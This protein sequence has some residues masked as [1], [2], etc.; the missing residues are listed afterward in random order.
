MRKQRLTAL[1]LAGALAGTT[2]LS[3]CAGQPDQQAA[4][5]AQAEDTA[6]SPESAS[7][8][9][10]EAADSA[11]DRSEQASDS[12]ESASDSSAEASDPADNFYDSVNHEQLAAWSI[13]EDKSSY[14]TFVVMENAKDERRIAALYLTGKDQKTR[15][16]GGF[17]EVEALLSQIREAKTVEELLR[18]TGQFN[19]DTHKYIFLTGFQISSDL[20]DSN[21]KMIMQPGVDTG[22]SR[23]EWLAEEE[24]D[25]KAAQYFKEYTQQLFELNGASEKEAAKK[26]EAVC[27]M[28][29]EIAK[30]GL[31]LA[32]MYDPEKTSNV[33]LVSE[34]PEAFPGVF[35]AEML[36]EVWGFAPE[37]RVNVVDVGALKKL[38]EYLTEEN[39]PLL[40]DYVLSTVYRN[41]AAYTTTDMREATLSYDQK[42]GGQ[43]GKKSEE[44]V[45]RLQI[46]SGAVEFE[47]GRLYAQAYSSEETKND[48]TGLIHE[49]IDVYRKRLT[50]LDWLG[51]ETRK[52]AI[53]KLEAID[54]R[55]AYPEVWE[56]DRYTAELKRPEDGGLYIDNQLAL[57][58]AQADYAYK[59][60]HDPV[61]KEYWVSAPQTV[62]AY[63]DPSANSITILSGILQAPFYDPEA[64]REENLGGIGFVIAHE[65]S[66]AFDTSGAQYDKNGNLAD[67]WTKEDKETFSRLANDVIAYYDRMGERFGR[68]NGT[69]TVT[70]NIADLGAISAVTELAKAEKLDLKKL[71]TAYAKCWAELVR[72]EYAALR[73]LSDTHAPNIL[74]VNAVLAATDAFYET[75]EVKEGDGMYVAPKERPR[76]W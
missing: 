26:T 47:C 5:G 52:Q 40:R 10:E 29:R 61:E 35:T 9:S 14:G 57:I 69:Q 41:F 62:N 70:E 22:I 37:E 45:L 30:A 68:V 36:E 74:R 65:I 15:D 58:K 7:D 56:Q 1:L 67:W 8:S 17:G 46:S 28:M 60:R 21:Q 32:E 20:E 66:H 18:V 44:E 24:E 71:Q 16:Q 38:A 43:P 55:A 12:Q 25:Q 3:G 2:V 48:V 50:E 42:L 27:A 51:E 73:Y 19:R 34:L 63:Y 49:V 54:I 39:L 31:S 64:S 76:I 11:S 4:S 53:E 13:P 6:D 59:T 72:P 23:E 75:F 33:Y